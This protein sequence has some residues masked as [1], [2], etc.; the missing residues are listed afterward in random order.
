MPDRLAEHA[1]VG[2]AFHLDREALDDLRGINAYHVASEHTVGLAVDDKLHKRALVAPR[3]RVLHRLE[4]RAVDVDIVAILPARLFLA[5]PDRADRW[6]AEYRGWHVLVVHLDRIIVVKRLGDR[7]ALRDRNRRQIEPIGDIAHCVD[8]RDAGALP[9]IDQDGAPLV[10]L[11]ADR[12]QPDPLG[13]RR[14]PGRVHDEIG[15]DLLADCREHRIAFA[16]RLLDA[17]DLRTGMHLDPASAH[18]LRQRDTQVVVK[19]VQQFLAPDDFDDI[20]SE[21]PEDADELD[22]DIAAPDDE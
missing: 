15:R 16:R 20:A 2:A 18:L 22:R 17:R 14:T 12:V 8:V 5:E 3:K 6:L 9:I 11:D 4:A 13:V 7:A 10:R 19:A 1:L 21:P